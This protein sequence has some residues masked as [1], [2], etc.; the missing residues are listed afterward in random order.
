[1]SDFLSIRSIF[2]KFKAA[3]ESIEPLDLNH[4]EYVCCCGNKA[5]TTLAEFQEKGHC[6]NC[7]GLTKYLKTTLSFVQQIFSNFGCELLSKEFVNIRSQL[8]FKCE[9]GE[10][11]TTT[12][13]MFIKSSYKKCKSCS[14]KKVDLARGYDIDFIKKQFELHGCTLLSTVY[15]GYNSELE[16]LCK[17]GRTGKTIYTTFIHSQYKQCGACSREQ[18]AKKQRLSYDYVFN[19]FK[20]GGCTL[21]S[22]EFLGT[23]VPV[24]YICECGNQ[25]E[26]LFWNF[27]NGRRCK[28]CRKKGGPPRLE[29]DYVKNFFAERNCTLLSELYETAGKL[30]DY[31]CECGKQSKISYN[32]FRDGHRCWDCGIKKTA[33]SRRLTLQEVQDFFKQNN[34]TLLSTTYVNNSSPLEYICVCGNKSTICF[35]SFQQGHRCGCIRSKGETMLAQILDKLKLEYTRQ[36]TYP[37][38]RNVYCLPFDF[39]VYYNGRIFLIEFDGL[40]HFKFVER[41]G[42]ADGF[43]QR[44]EHDHI[45]NTY[46]IDNDI[47]ILRISS[48]EIDNMDFILKIYMGLIDNNIAPP[49][50]FTNK[51]LYENMK[52]KITDAPKEHWF[53][54]F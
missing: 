44:I 31:I 38:C 49:I 40:Q 22:E 25:S 47:P 7:N 2:N 37:D 10:I 43:A 34:C 50:T 14:K 52:N 32:A 54:E 16:F 13:D 36:H 46:C 1:M 18:T 12:Y 35:S 51:K 48:K 6:D 26:I 8:E 23:T 15:S 19:V 29:Y 53:L 5:I 27:K 9:C 24:Q 4:L 42:G 21:I 39:Y 41:F 3:L 30:L 20:E 33:D 11:D 28:D 45:K 17:C